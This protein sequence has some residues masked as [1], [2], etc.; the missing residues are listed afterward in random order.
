MILNYNFQLQSV[1]KQ[2]FLFKFLKLINK[3]QLKEKHAFVSNSNKY[4]FSRKNYLVKKTFKIKKNIFVKELIVLYIKENLLTK[5]I[6]LKK[7][8]KIF[9]II[10]KTK[11]EY[12]YFVLL[13]VKYFK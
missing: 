4:K 11:N 8:K 7:K 13:F 5:V 9:Q 1:F 12:N 10:S 3:F 6:P 2:F